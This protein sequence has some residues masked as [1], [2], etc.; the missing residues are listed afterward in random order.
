MCEPA[1]LIC[2]LSSPLGLDW[3]SGQSAPYGWKARDFLSYK[4]CLTRLPDRRTYVAAI[5]FF[6]ANRTR[7]RKPS[8]KIKKVRES[9]FQL[10]QNNKYLSTLKRPAEAKECWNFKTSVEVQQNFC[11]ELV[12][13]F[14]EEATKQP[15]E[16]KASLSRIW[17]WPGAYELLC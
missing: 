16:R 15:S 11:H 8:S 12:G 1:K 17:S 7:W 5:V 2:L 10:Q 4:L 3:K 13:E 6:C 14:G 9:F